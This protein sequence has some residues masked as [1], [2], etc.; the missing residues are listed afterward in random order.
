LRD[1]LAVLLVAKGDDAAAVDGH[2]ERA[3]GA[4][5]RGAILNVLGN[6]HARAAERHPSGVEGAAAHDRHPLGLDRGGPN[7]LL[8]RVRPFE[9]GARGV[10]EQRGRCRV[11]RTRAHEHGCRHRPG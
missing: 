1:D 9:G 3:I 4:R 10:I 5:G 11:E 7:A 8:R 6:A 2:L